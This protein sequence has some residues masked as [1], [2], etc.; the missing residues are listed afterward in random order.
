MGTSYADALKLAGGVK[1]DTG[2]ILSGG[3]MMGFAVYSLE[4]P[5]MKNTSGITLLGM[6]ELSQFTSGPCIRCGRCVD[7][8]PMSLR[9]GMLSVM[10]ESCA[11]EQAEGAHV[12]HC[13]E[14]GCCSYVCPSSRPLVQHLRRGKA[15]A[16]A[17]R[18]AAEGK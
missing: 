4:I 15:E 3:P 8:C 13:I 14:C 16:V 7:A 5:V 1:C 18:R 2:K 6:D 9:P 17:R 10:I 11:F 12:E